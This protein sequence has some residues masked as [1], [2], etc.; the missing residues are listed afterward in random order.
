M[1]SKFTPEEKTSFFE[2]YKDAVEKSSE[3]VKTTPVAMDA[4]AGEE[5]ASD[6]DSSLEDTSLDS[7]IEF[8]NQKIEDL[9]KNKAKAEELYKRKRSEIMQVDYDEISEIDASIDAVESKENQLRK[10]FQGTETRISQK[11]NLAITAES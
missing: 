9:N 3:P 1:I 8:K 11:E 5:T 6:T 10:F 4:T 7:S 2:K